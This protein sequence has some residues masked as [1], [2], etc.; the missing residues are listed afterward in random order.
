MTNNIDNE[1]SDN[2]ILNILKLAGIEKEDN[3]ISSNNNC[4]QNSEPN[5]NIDRYNSS[6]TKT[7]NVDLS[8]FSED[9]KK[10]FDSINFEN[11]LDCYNNFVNQLINKN[12]EKETAERIVFE[13]IK[14]FYENKINNINENN[15]N[16]FKKDD[17]YHE[18]NLETENIF[19]KIRIKN[20]NNGEIF[21]K[22]QIKVSNCEDL[23][24]I[25]NMLCDHLKNIVEKKNKGENFKKNLQENTIIIKRDPYELKS[26]IFV[27]DFSL[28]K[29]LPNFSRQKL[30]KYGDNTMTYEIDTQKK[31]TK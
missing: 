11:W 19:V 27:S 18:E 29:K 2:F 7:L 31:S 28:D 16:N 10:T 15:E 17:D 9:V 4:C 14:N 22:C 6:I 8:S 3:N 5:N 12:F 25:V 20:E 24:K 30:A 23:E 13:I 21:G 26:C 1:T